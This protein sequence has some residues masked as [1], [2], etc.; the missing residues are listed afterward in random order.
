MKFCK[1]QEAD[2]S[3]CMHDA[4]PLSCCFWFRCLHQEIASL[5]SGG[6]RSGG[7]VCEFGKVVGFIVQ[8][9]CHSDRLL[10]CSVLISCFLLIN[11]SISFSKLS[12]S[13]HSSVHFNT[14]SSVGLIVF[15]RI[16][17]QLCENRPEGF[18][19]HST[20]HSRVP[21][22]CF[23]DV[24][25]EPL[26]T[27]TFLLLLLALLPMRLAA[28]RSHTTRLSKA[29]RSSTVADHSS[30]HQKPSII[31]RVLS[32]LYYVLIVAMIA[33]LSLEIARLIVA[34]LGI[35]LLPFNYLGIILVLLNRITW[36]SKTSR[37]A[38]IFFWTVL[39]ITTALKTAAEQSEQDSPYRRV[40][41]ITTQGQ[42]PTSDEALDNAIMVGVQLVLATL[43]FN[44]W[45][46][47][48]RV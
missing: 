41:G 42:Y 23:L 44:G 12:R 34:E 38:N 28:R 29:E 14:T 22:T 18:G 16:M 26:T 21:T 1:R 45:G 2:S 17:M 31:S 30:R 5:S 40:K 15:R 13:A 43:E 19:P 35:G 11:N 10:A 7:S 37:L 39:L 8:V 47:L 20:I 9:F 4:L 3:T 6:S 27:W 33:M 48:P 25:V 24:I 46:R 36:K 32:V